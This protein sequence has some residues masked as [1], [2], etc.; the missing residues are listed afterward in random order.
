VTSSRLYRLLAR[1]KY[2]AIKILDA[3]DAHVLN[4]R[5]Y[6]RGFC[7]WL[8]LHPW[9]GERERWRRTHRPRP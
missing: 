3:F 9:W 1:F 2:G 5:G 8:G 4:H 6:R 7:A